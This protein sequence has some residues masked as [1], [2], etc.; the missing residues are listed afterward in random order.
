[1]ADE[2]QA[3]KI[4]AVPLEEA[5]RAKGEARVAL[6][7]SKVAGLRAFRRIRSDRLLGVLGVIVTVIG[8]AL[9]FT[10]EAPPVI[11]KKYKVE[12]P[13]TTHSVEN[14]TKLLTPASPTDTKTFPINAKNVTEVVISVYWKDTVGDVGMEGD[15]FAI[16]V[17]GPASSGVDVKDLDLRIWL[18]H[19]RTFTFSLS[20]VPELASVAATNDAQART[21]IGDKSND[22]GSGDWQVTMRLLRAN[23]DY[24][25]GFDDPAVKERNV[26]NEPFCTTD[27]GQDFIVSITYVTYSLKYT[28]LF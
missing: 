24:D 21:A 6:P 16:S 26:C 15:Q 11:E 12:W 5:R 14:W 10:W 9:M 2:K 28:K 7:R 13:A 27:T 22:T 18:E 4:I 19:R 8:V 3:P 1:M 25:P 20:G 17:K 23:H